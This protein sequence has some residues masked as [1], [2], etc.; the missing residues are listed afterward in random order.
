M[1]NDFGQNRST[2]NTFATWNIFIYIRF[3]EGVFKHKEKNLCIFRLSNTWCSRWNEIVNFKWSKQ[4]CF[5][6][7]MP[8]HGMFLEWWN[9]TKSPS[10][11]W[12]HFSCLLDEGIPKIRKKLNS[13]NGFLSYLKNS[14]AN[15]FHMAD[16]FCL[17]LVCPQ[18][19]TMRIQFLPYF[20]N[21]LIK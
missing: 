16:D 19:T 6:V 1:Y 3:L 10:S 17:A 21:P 14:T 9:R 5:W 4:W 15:S 18:K 2:F 13:H 11:I 12:Q 8:V 7:A 20:W